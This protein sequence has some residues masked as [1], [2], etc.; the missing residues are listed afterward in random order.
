MDKF[1]ERPPAPRHI[2]VKKIVSHP[3]KIFIIKV[4]VMVME[5]KSDCSHHP[6]SNVTLTR[7]LRKTPFDVIWF[8]RMIGW[9]QLAS[10]IHTISIS[11]DSS[12]VRLNLVFLDQC[13]SMYT[14]EFVGEGLILNFLFLFF[15][16]FLKNKFLTRT[17]V[18]V[19]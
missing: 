6:P 11:F 19:Y 5:E 9:R 13:C 10:V 15:L 16:I 14:T 4:N 7:L 8:V 12:M 2:H 3:P 1:L 17:L 18:C